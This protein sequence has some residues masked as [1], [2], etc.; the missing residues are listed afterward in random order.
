MGM[1]TGVLIRR[2]IMRETDEE[3]SLD[4]K[5]FVFFFE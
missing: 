5:E 2:G 4:Q 3:M 1:S